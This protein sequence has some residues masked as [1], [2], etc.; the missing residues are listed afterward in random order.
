MN[1]SW[2]K[3]AADALIFALAVLA[4]D[5]LTHAVMQDGAARDVCFLVFIPI[6]GFALHKARETVVRRRAN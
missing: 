4:S 2:K 6:I 3:Y 1:A 5:V